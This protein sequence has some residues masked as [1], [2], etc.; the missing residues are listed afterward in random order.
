MN[1]RPEDR[2]D[3][4]SQ[5]CQPRDREPNFEK[6]AQAASKQ[7]LHQGLAIIRNVEVLH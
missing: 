7:E 4:G 5:R 2:G 1:G 3:K 6:S